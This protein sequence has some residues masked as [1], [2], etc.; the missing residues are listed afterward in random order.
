MALLSWAVVVVHIIVAHVLAPT[1]ARDFIIPIMPIMGV[2]I[3][4]H[5]L[6]VAQDMVAMDMDVTVMA[7][8][9]AL[10]IIIEH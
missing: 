6:G 5:I 2:H 9:A 8:Q 10:P 7:V 4:I 1:V 3:F